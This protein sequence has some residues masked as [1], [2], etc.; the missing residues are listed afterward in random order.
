[1][2]QRIENIWRTYA[3]TKSADFYCEHQNDVSECG[4]YPAI[5]RFLDTN[6]WDSVS[7]SGGY[8]CVHHLPPDVPKD[9]V[10]K[11]RKKYGV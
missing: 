11:A 4:N 9:L 2:S 5:I 6:D 3:I 7:F 8:F 1:M 10:E